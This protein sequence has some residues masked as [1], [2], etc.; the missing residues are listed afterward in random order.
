MSS[1]PLEQQ[2]IECLDAIAH[3]IDKTKDLLSLSLT[4]K[5]LYSLV[6]YRHFRFRVISC[7]LEDPS[8]V[9]VWDLLA[10]NKALARSVRV[11]QIRPDAGKGG[12]HHILPLD[13]MDPGPNM[14]K[15][16]KGKRRLSGYECSAMII[17][18]HFIPALKQMTRL[19]SF[20]W[21]L[22]HRQDRRIFHHDPQG[23]QIKICDALNSC[24]NLRSIAIGEYWHNI[25][26]TFFGVRCLHL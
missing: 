6:S 21:R 23:L 10:R 22:D 19:M 25:E 12:S 8:P 1:S 3:E 15:R 16:K 2:P 13:D 18:D 11:L 17:L 24:K 20:S 7:R 9:Q 4:C 5:A 14:K 26:K